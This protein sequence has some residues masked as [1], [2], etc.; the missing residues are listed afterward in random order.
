[1]SEP[2][3][4]ASPRDVLVGLLHTARQQPHDDTPRLIVA[5]WLEE[6]GDEVDCARAE[7]VRL[8][9][10]LRLPPNTGGRPQALLAAH[11]DAWL[12]PLAKLGDAVRFERGMVALNL[13]VSGLVGRAGER[14]M[15]GEAM[16]WLE[17]VT[18]RQANDASVATF[19]SSPLLPQIGNL[20]ISCADLGVEAGRALMRST[21][22]GGLVAI[23]VSNNHLSNL[24]AGALAGSPDLAGL[25]SL[26]LQSNSIS[27]SG[28]LALARSCHLQ[29][30][31]YLNLGGNS[32]RDEGMGAIAAS[33][34]LA[35]V[36]TL[37]VCGNDIWDEGA[38]RLAQSPMVGKMRRL[39]LSDNEIGD[40][41]ALAMAQSRHLKSLERL[42]LARNRITDVGAWALLQSPNLSRLAE[43]DL[44]GNRLSDAMMK[45]VRGRFPGREAEA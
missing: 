3:R 9:V 16:A 4:I 2:A 38:G 30:L 25:R 15:Q 43:V 17:K 41:G 44:A 22:T 8:Q 33:P 21:S 29:N 19:V 32:I 13:P 36:E 12:G 7:F 28:A 1:M 26:C 39:R 35:N 6:F 40:E 31:R 27:V 5:D 11:R 20:V 45:A 10:G 37:F 34:L 14:L 42:N 23:D 18:L 24:G